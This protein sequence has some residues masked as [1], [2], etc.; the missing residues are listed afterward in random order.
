[1]E[2]PK[3]NYTTNG[4]I[5][6]LIEPSG[7]A[8]KIPSEKIKIPLGEGLLW[9]HLDT[10]NTQ[11]SQWLRHHSQLNP[12]AIEAL[13]F[14]E[15]RPRTAPLD[16]GLFIA[17]R[18]VNNAVD[19]TWE[20][21]VSIRLWVQSTLIVSACRY[22]LDAINDLQ[23]ALEAGSGPKNAGQFLVRLSGLLFNRVAAV[24]EL[25]DDRVDALDNQVV[26]HLPP[27]RLFRPQLAQLRRQV[28]NIRRFLSPQR[29]AI[30]H[31]FTEPPPWLEENDRFLLRELWDRTVQQIETLDLARDRA[32][33]IQEEI[34]SRLSEALDRR[35]YKFSLVTII[36]LPL[37]FLTSLLGINVGGVPGAKGK[38]SFEIVSLILFGIVAVEYLAFRI[39]KW[40]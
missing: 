32:A 27:A 14:E 37:M 1:M 18:S 28:I 20:D 29:E 17:F 2:Q 16:G 26:K 7:T 22:P 40:L 36:F 10:A 8:K 9:V 35:S 25:L 30:G 6:Y 21:L 39:K 15:A 4:I 24:L 11:A 31:L 23:K 13:E 33:A 34:N 38:W 12:L 19:T 5:A 3:P